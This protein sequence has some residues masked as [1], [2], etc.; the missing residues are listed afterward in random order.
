[1]TGLDRIEVKSRQAPKMAK[2]HT[3][4]HMKTKTSKPNR[5]MARKARKAGKQKSSSGRIK[6]RQKKKEM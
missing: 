3:K 5:G 2:L 1:M 4:K 6:A